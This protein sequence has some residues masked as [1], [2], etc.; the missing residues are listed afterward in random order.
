[1]ALSSE[2]RSRRWCTRVVNW[3][4]HFGRECQQVLAGR[5]WHDHF[6]REGQQV[7]VGRPVARLARPRIIHATVV[8]TFGT[9]RLGRAQ[10][11]PCSGWQRPGLVRWHDG[12]VAIRRSFSS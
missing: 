9:E 11:H 6:G 8:A 7:R 4:D 5:P 12:A 3:H 1:M 2:L 10:W